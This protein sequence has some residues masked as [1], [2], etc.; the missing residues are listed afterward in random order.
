MIVLFSHQMTP[1]KRFGPIAILTSFIVLL[2]ADVFAQNLTPH[3]ISLANAK[4]FALN[5]P[6][7][8][9]INVAAQGLKRVRFMALSP[10]NRLFV[11]DMY[12]LSDNRR[13]VVDILDQGRNRFETS[14]T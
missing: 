10:D 12:N 2:S 1:P 11:T 7:G 6:E 3:H 14:E 13:G 5:L 4:S 8:Y 9:E